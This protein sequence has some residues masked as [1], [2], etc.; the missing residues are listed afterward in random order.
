M[1]YLLPIGFILAAVLII[2]LIKVIS[3]LMKIL[4]YVLL[5][6]VILG[7]VFTYFLVKD[8]NAFAKGV[9]EKPNLFLLKEGNEIVSGFS[10]FQLNISTSDSLSENEINKATGYLG[11]KEYKKIVGDNYKLIIIDKKAFQKTDK[12]DPDSIISFVQKQKDGLKIINQLMPEDIPDT[13]AMAFSLLVIYSLKEDPF[14]IVK[15]YK[16]GNIIIYE[17][18]FVFKVFRFFSGGKKA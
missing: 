11:K 17:E 8:A 6:A 14:F 4:L 12:F 13:E 7:G 3:G 5:I 9:S 2:L 15:E 10:I 16:K 1:D 18:T